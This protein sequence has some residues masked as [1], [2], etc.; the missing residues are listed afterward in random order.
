MCRETLL[1]Y[2]RCGHVKSSMGI[3]YHCP[4]WAAKGRTCLND[5]GLTFKDYT[6][7]IED[8]RTQRFLDSHETSIPGDW[9]TEIALGY[10]GYCNNCV[11]GRTE[12]RNE[13]QR[14]D[15]LDVYLGEYERWGREAEKRKKMAVEQE[16]LI[17][18]F[19][20]QKKGETEACTTEAE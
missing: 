10:K 16:R 14:Q 4:S 1:I 6:F 5:I 20:T 8:T 13:R 15:F 7:I 2:P 19:R 9:K 11:E 18:N 3:I 17:Q 12:P